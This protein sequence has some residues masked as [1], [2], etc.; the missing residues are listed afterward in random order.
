MWLALDDKYGTIVSPITR[1]K[2]DR[3]RRKLAQQE[4]EQDDDDNATIGLGMIMLI[5]LMSIVVMNWLGDMG[6]FRTTQER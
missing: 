3:A 5:P 1:Q 2:R 4:G 6:F